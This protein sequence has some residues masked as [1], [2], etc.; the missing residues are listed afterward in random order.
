M[1]SGAHCVN[2]AKSGKESGGAG[3][4]S[5]DQIMKGFEQ[6]PCWEDR[7][8][9]LKAHILKSGPP[10]KKWAPDIDELPLEL[11]PTVLYA[12][13]YRCTCFWRELWH[14]FHHSLSRVGQ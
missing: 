13:I 4:A 1:G 12:S 9:I 8:L 14:N 5:Q 11:H 2:V 6:R 10:Q 3:E 7:I